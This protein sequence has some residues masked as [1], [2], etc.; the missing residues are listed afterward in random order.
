V[1]PVQLAVHGKRLEHGV[2]SACSRLEP[3][4][5]GAAAM[6]LGST[7]RSEGHAWLQRMNGCLTIQTRAAIDPTKI[8]A[9][10]PAMNP[11]V[12]NIEE[13]PVTENKHRTCQRRSRLSVEKCSLACWGSGGAIFLEVRSPR[14]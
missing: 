4:P 2:G 5:Q 3:R 11:S 9:I 6:L 12:N 7:R 1:K 14:R 8:T 10:A 13:L